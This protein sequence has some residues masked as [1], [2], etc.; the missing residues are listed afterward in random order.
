M[1]KLTTVA[2]A[3]DHPVL[4]AGMV[5]LFAGSDRHQ[6]V[7]QA[8]CADS[9]LEIVKAVSPDVI[10][11]DL[12]M[13]GDVFRTIAQIVATAP[14][15]KVVVFTAFCSIESA[16]KALD[17]GATGFALKGSPSSELLEAIDTVMA[18]QMFVTRQYASQVMNG[19][20]DRARRQAL[21]ES[22]K[23]NVRE[24]QIVGHLMQA[25]TNRE[26]AAALHISEKTVKHYMTGLMLKL[27]ARNRVEVVIA[28]RLSQEQ[29][30]ALTR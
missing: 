17:A 22:I 6:I 12:S 24:K 11:M 1:R 2:I 20:R 19:L 7:G 9:S 3:D 15:T 5:S 30:S 10:I 25:R 4:L 23:L 14:D 13:P 16:L 27:K 26:I 28:S 18:G 29:E 21:D 8:V